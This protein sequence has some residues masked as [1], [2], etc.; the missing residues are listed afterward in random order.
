[1]HATRQTL[2]SSFTRSPIR[3]ALLLLAI[4]FAVYG[5][6]LN[7]HFLLDDESQVL[8]NELIHN[9]SN[10]PVFFLGSTMHQ[11][12]AA[13]GGIYYKPIMSMCYSLLW[14]MDPGNSLPY[15]FFQLI[16][17]I[18]NALLVWGLLKRHMSELAALLM[19]ILFLVHP[20]NTEVV[21]Y[22]ADLQD[23]LYTFFGL[24]ALNFLADTVKFSWPRK[25]AFTVLLLCSVLSK[26][27]GVL[28]F[29]TACVYAGVFKREHLRAVLVIAVLTLAFY[30][31]LRIDIAHLTALTY[32]QNRIGRAPFDVRL[33]TAPLVL[34][35][36]LWKFV[37]PRDLTATQDWVVTDPSLLDFWLP[38]AGCVVV[39]AASVW[40][41]IRYWRTYANNL[42]FAFFVFWVFMGMGFHSHI[43]V[44]LDGTVADRW[45]YF[46][47]VGL[48]AMLGLL[49][50]QLA[51]TKFPRAGMTVCL[52]AILAL[53]VRSSIRSL[54]WHD[55][56]TLCLHDL[57]IFPDSYD[58]HNNLGVEL[59]RKGKVAEAKKEFE[60][61]VELAPGW[62]INWN[63]LGAAFNALGDSQQAE[64][65]YL[66][67]MEHGTYYMAYENYASVLLVQ[68]RI[69]EAK[70]FISEKALPLFPASRSLRLMWSAIQD[71]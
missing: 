46:S 39:L 36:Y 51:L 30:F 13:L 37:F 15:H 65:S 22:I 27:S 14:W 52:A 42:K 58:M 24:L 63:N 19:A 48:V 3:V 54:D 45:F 71:K 56:Y 31:W 17:M 50:D 57:Q 47:S 25:L 35:S 23:V 49:F 1:M 67:S 5:W 62:D 40:Y 64:K 34:W 21:A 61:S 2:I 6:S 53:S 41:A 12:G 29:V 38:L 11:A 9:P 8:Q 18:A 32:S 43:A 10:W 68:G 7:N 33:L 28:Y 44:S 20:I 70:K 69:P 4:G 16:M 59:F 55:N 60:R 66:T 26:E